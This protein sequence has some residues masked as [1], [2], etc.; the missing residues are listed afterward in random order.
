MS[1]DSYSLRSV[2]LSLG[3]R[4]LLCSIPH[5]YHEDRHF[6][7]F[8]IEGVRLGGNFLFPPKTSPRQEKLFTCAMKVYTISVCYA[9]A[10]TVSTLSA[11]QKLMRFES[12]QIFPIAAAASV[13]SLLYLYAVYCDA[14]QVQPSSLLGRCAYFIGDHAEDMADCVAIA[15]TALFSAVIPLL[16]PVSAVLAIS[17]NLLDLCDRHSWLPL[18]AATREQGREYL[19]NAWWVARLALGPLLE[20]AWVV[21]RKGSEWMVSYVGIPYAVQLLKEADENLR[22]CLPDGDRYSAVQDAMRNLLSYYDR[23]VALVDRRNVT[24][25]ERQI[26]AAARADIVC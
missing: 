3:K 6:S 19:T 11:A 17:F 7:A 10:A 16:H 26:I 20:K 8:W 4:S 18:T 5:R 14:K 24:E 25:C 2:F 12:R 1:L 15:T 22:Q 9:Y 21:A 23:V 13:H